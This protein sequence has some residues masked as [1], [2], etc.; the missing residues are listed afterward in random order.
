VQLSG[1]V[2]IYWHEP[3]TDARGSQF[4]LVNDTTAKESRVII[5][6]YWAEARTRTEIR[7]RLVT[8]KRFGWSDESQ[9][10]AQR[11][12]EERAADAAARMVR[13]ESLLWFDHKVPYNGGNGLPIREEIVARHG[14]TVITRNSYGALCLNT[15]DVLFA[16]IDFSGEPGSR[17]YL[18]ALVVMVVLAIAAGVYWESWRIVGVGLVAGMVRCW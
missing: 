18:G 7:D 1:F 17:T 3:Y 8:V 11:H 16:D 15:P 13:G 9:A 6:Q 12:A 10:A 2:A 4:D 5:P 14:E